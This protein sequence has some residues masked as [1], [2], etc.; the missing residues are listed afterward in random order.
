MLAPRR[1][2][3]PEDLEGVTRL[4]AVVEAADGHH[5]I[6]EHQYLEL[7][8]RSIG[9][10]VGL[11]IEND[12]APVAYA[13][14][15]RGFEP[16][17]WTV[18]A[19]LHPAW[20]TPDLFAMLLA[21]ATAEAARLGGSWLRLWAHLP[22]LIDGAVA[23]GF[24]PERELRS[25]R[26]MLPA[27][28][29]A[30]LPQGVRLDRFSSGRDEGELLE[31]NNAAFAG[32]PENGNWT[33]HILAHRM[34]RSWFVP[35]DLIVVRRQGQMLG[36]CWTKRER[37]EVGEIYVIAVAPPFQGQ[38]LGK[39]LLLEG[40]AHLSR[41][42]ARSSVLYVDSSNHRAMQLYDSVGFRLDHVDRSF[43]TGLV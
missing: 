37:P 13:G 26:R 35:N 17:W 2:V 8:G 23:L 21:A 20:R 3:F 36:F 4:L 9:A 25:L 19:A 43:V 5:P 7:T 10:A 22:H 6:G 29:R 15:T 31:V 40:L 30:Q 28:E 18:E 24:R 11:V 33:G 39:A 16:S 32:H 34:Q 41:K 12:G 14:L 27:D 38:R 1:A 42:G